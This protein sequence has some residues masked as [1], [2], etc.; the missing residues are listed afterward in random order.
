MKALLSAPFPSS[1]VVA[2]ALAV[3]VLAAAVALALRTPEPSVAAEG[4]ASI[5]VEA[6]LDS[7][8]GATADTAASCEITVD[9]QRLTGAARYEVKFTAPKGVDLLTAPVVDGEN[10]YT[11]PYV[12]SGTYRV[13]VT[14]FRIE[15]PP[16]P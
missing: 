2:T 10:T 13:R 1:L 9:F 11:V 12:G 4:P 8:D 5:A 16:I 6:T 14:A 15:T 3:A 7:C